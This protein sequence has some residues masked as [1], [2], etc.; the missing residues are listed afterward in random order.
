MNGAKWMLLGLVAMLAGPVYAHHGT[1]G[2]YD[3]AKVV[4]VRGV[5]KEFRWRNPHSALFIIAKDESGKEVTYAMEMGSPVTLVRLGYSRDTFKP[6]DQAEVEMHPSFTN[7]VNGY[8]PTSLKAVV[9]G[10]V[11]RTGKAE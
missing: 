7:P 6:G 3:E 10:K 1:A 11:M 9:N 4:T 2:S 5:V 8:S